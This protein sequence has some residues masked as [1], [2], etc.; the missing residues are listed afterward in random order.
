MRSTG[1]RS[2]HICTS[3]MYSMGLGARRRPGIRVVYHADDR[4]RLRVSGERDVLPH[5]VLG[6][7]RAAAAAD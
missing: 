3:E 4:Q 1:P 6:P 2:G 5:R 7:A